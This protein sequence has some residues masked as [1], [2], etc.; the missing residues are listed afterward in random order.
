M[1]TY[2]YLADYRLLGL[3]PGCSAQTLERTW[4]RAVSALHPDRS[5]SGS[6]DPG[7]AQQRLL[8]L[9]QAYRRLRDFER[10]HGRLP[11]APL[12]NPT[13]PDTPERASQTA[14]NAMSWEMA[15]GATDSQA[16]PAAPVPGAVSSPKP[17]GR[18]R[19]ALG[20][21][22]LGLAI[23]LLGWPGREPVEAP[24]EAQQPAPANALGLGQPA[25]HAGHRPLIKLGH[26]QA[27]VEALL[28]PPLLR[29]QED[30]EYGPSHIRFEQGRVSGWYSSPLR[31]LPVDRPLR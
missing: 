7:A 23:G 9:T 4:R 8:Q 11:G 2:D 20:G 14:E 15:A 5:Q 31:P 21:I 13:A 16:T 26:T 6:L 24:V 29:S 10:E 12:P 30:W 22:G 25:P 18:R 3:H 1:R 17:S 28:G 27:E 19:V